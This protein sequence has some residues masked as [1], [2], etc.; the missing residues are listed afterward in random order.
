M[1][2][3]I[4]L[5]GALFV[6]GG[7]RYLLPSVVSGTSASGSIVVEVVPLVLAGA[8]LGIVALILHRG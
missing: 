4:T 1:T 3:V 8:T 5:I 7:A 2:A 6:Y